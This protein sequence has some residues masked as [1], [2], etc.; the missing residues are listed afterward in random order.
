M[1]GFDV[2]FLRHAFMF[3]ERVE[4]PE[5]KLPPLA[6]ARGHKKEKEKEKKAS[7]EKKQES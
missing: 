7:Q 6:P 4:Q 3:S 5:V 1:A 2:I